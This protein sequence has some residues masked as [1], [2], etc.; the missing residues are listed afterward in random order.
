M[1]GADI[2]V[3]LQRISKALIYA[4]LDE[5]RLEF[6]VVTEEW[7]DLIRHMNFYGG[8]NFP[9]DAKEITYLGIVIKNPDAPVA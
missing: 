4:H 2:M 8:P 6:R 9:F 5:H 3:K 7:S 1:T